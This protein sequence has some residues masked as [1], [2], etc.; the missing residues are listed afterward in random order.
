MGFDLKHPL[1]RG[2]EAEARIRPPR[3]GMHNGIAPDLRAGANSRHA[4]ATHNFDE[5]RNRSAMDD[6]DTERTELFREI[7]VYPRHFLLQREIGRA[8]RYAETVSSQR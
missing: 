2:L 8:G 4:L 5:V 1:P 7:C 3:S 6:I